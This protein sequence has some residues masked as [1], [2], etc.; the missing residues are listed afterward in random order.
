M[1][2]T[3][4]TR[5]VWL[6]QLEVELLRTRELEAA[7]KER[8]DAQEK[9]V[10][11]FKGKNVPRPQS[12]RLLDLMRETHKLQAGHVRLV[13]NEILERQPSRTTEPIGA[14]IGSSYCFRRGK[15]D[16]ALKASPKGPMEAVISH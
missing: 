2:A 14:G 11:R 4:S 7:G 1:A 16:F 5:H 10:A 13:E 12:E 6:S 8:V 15:A 9:R 3:V